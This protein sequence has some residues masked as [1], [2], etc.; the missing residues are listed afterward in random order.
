MDLRRP[1]MSQFFTND[2]GHDG[3]GARIPALT[4]ALPL[5]GHLRARCYS[6]M[7]GVSVPSHP[8]AKQRRKGRV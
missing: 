5:S 4:R 2:K 6:P 8:A 3:G 7:S 1:L